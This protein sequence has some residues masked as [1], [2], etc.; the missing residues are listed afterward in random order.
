MSPPPKA[1]ID[2]ARETVRAWENA[3]PLWQHLVKL[4]EITAALDAV[5]TAPAVVGASIY[6]GKSDLS[7]QMQHAGV[8]VNNVDAVRDFLED[9]GS[10]Q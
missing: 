8:D 2:A 6:A 4:R 3:E 1:L 5:E 10:V 7:A 9:S